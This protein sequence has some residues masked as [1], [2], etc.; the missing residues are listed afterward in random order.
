MNDFLMAA[1]SATADAPNPAAVEVLA[2]AGL[3]VTDEIAATPAFT[4]VR[5]ANPNRTKAPIR[6]EVDR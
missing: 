4:P 5:T 6:Q 3:D 1:A 2:E